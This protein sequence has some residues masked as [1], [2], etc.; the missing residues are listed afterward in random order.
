LTDWGSGRKKTKT[1]GRQK[2][3]NTATTQTTKVKKRTQSTRRRNLGKTKPRG[4]SHPANCKSTIPGIGG[5]TCG[6][7]P[8]HKS[9][10]WRRGV[11]STLCFRNTSSTAKTVGLHGE[12][13]PL[14]RR[15][16]LQAA[17]WDRPQLGRGKRSSNRS[18][19]PF[20]KS[21]RKLPQRSDVAGPASFRHG[22][23]FSGNRSH[24]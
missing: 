9:G 20:E 1:E 19:K 14:E 23:D 24:R 18:R 11:K 3:G 21:C 17:L 2:A 15:E 22:Y 13:R 8:R 7:R 5:V 4:G 12:A 6:L 16:Y 10:P